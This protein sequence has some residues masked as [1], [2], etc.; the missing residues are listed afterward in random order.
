MQYN[1]SLVLKVFILGL[2]L[3]AGGVLWRLYT[4]WNEI[5]TLCVGIGLFFFFCS[6]VFALF[7]GWMARTGASRLP[8]DWD[9][10]SAEA[11]HNL[12]RERVA[13][14]ANKGSKSARVTLWL[15]QMSESQKYRQ[16]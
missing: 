16:K 1:W 12:A 6:L 4:G 11:R 14:E 7:Y 5:V 2:F 15:M 13:E 9:K 10:L 3:T 8:V